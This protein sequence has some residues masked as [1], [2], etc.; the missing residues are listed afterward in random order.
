MNNLLSY[1][2][3]I[4]HI[5]KIGILVLLLNAVESCSYQNGNLAENKDTK[6]SLTDSLY[7]DTLT[8]VYN[9]I[10]ETILET[11]TNTVEFKNERG[12]LAYLKN[13]FEQN[14]ISDTINHHTPEILHQIYY[15]N[16][17]TLFDD[18]AKDSLAI[19]KQ[20]K[21]PDTI[22]INQTLRDRYYGNPNILNIQAQLA[23]YSFSR[24]LLSADG[25]LAVVY[26]NFECPFC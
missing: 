24:P 5:I 1:R 10:L 14:N 12:Q 26:M 18:W 23:H 15:E 2:P 22:F 25:K 11:D 6:Y 20:A 3:L 9:D 4:K 19:V 21:I 17:K 8:S 13:Y 16:L 7:I